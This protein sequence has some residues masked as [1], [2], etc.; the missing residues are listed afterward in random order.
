MPFKTM[1]RELATLSPKLPISGVTLSMVGANSGA[2]VSSVRTN[3]R[4]GPL[5][6]AGSTCDKERSWLP[7][8]WPCKSR[9]NDHF[10]V[11]ATIVLPTLF[12]SKTTNTFAPGSPRPES[13]IGFFPA[14]IPS[15]KS[16]PTPA[17]PVMDESSRTLPGGVI[18]INHAIFGKAS[19]LRPA[20]SWILLLGKILN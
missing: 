11:L 17:I 12:P 19:S 10:P 9:L 3:V 13:T 16:G 7:S 2:T 5:F 1:A 8:A 18:S 14:S 15:T 6:P 20:I 4:I